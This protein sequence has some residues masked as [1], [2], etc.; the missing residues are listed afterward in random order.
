MPFR[1]SLRA[2][3]RLR[4]LEEQRER[5]RLMLLHS[6]RASLR[7][8]FEEVGREALAEFEQLD[9][10]LRAGLSG[11]ELLLEEDVLQASRGRRRELTALMESLEVQVRMQIST[12]SESQKKRKI[13]ERLRERQ[14]H[15]YEQVDGR[16]EQ[17]RI[18]D[19][20]ARRRAPGGM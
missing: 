3:L 8:E 19:L 18:D 10:R 20:F 1:F 14:L 5:M 12:F 6:S 17:Q 16:R 4:H 7:N 11:A 9:H 15:A 2:L 13:L